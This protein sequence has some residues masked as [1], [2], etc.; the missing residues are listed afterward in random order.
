MINTILNVSVKTKDNYILFSTIDQDMSTIV[1]KNSYS[2]SRYLVVFPTNEKLKEYVKTN[3]TDLKAAI[4]FEGD[5]KNISY[6]IRYH[7]ADAGEFLN[8]SISEE[9][10]L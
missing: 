7:R 10:Y 5:E 1:I 9:V 6:S 8:F 3:S 4:I 2:N